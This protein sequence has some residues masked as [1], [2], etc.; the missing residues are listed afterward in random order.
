[1][2]PDVKVSVIIAVYNPGPYLD[3]PIGSLQRQTMPAGEWEAILVDDGST[4]GSGDRLDAIAA[5]NP[6]I[7]AVHIPNSGWPGTPRNV[8]LPMARGEHVL[9]MDH[10]D[11]LGTEAL[12]R[13]YDFAEST[14]ADVVVAKEVGHGFG[15]PLMAFQRTIPDARLGEDPLL[16]LL[17]PHKLFRRSMLEAHGVRFPDGKRRLE[18][19]L[20]VMPAY[21]G[22]KRI[23][24][25][26][27]YPAYHW[28]RRSNDANAS[29]TPVDPVAYYDAVREILD[30]VDAHTE[31]GPLRDEL[32][33]HWYR[34]KTL[35]K[36][37]GPRWTGLS[38]TAGTKRRF[39]EIRRITDERF[40]SRLD[41]DLPVRYRYLARA[42]RAGRMDLVRPHATLTDAIDTSVKVTSLTT[43]E[44]RIDAVLDCTLRASGR[45]LRFDQ[46]DGRAFW[47]PPDELADP[48]LS[49]ADLD[50]TDDLA[51]A[52]VL[53]I[54]RHRASAAEYSRTFPLELRAE[55]GVTISAGT[56]R[57]EID[58]NRFAAGTQLAN[59]VWDGKLQIWIGGWRGTS[60]LPA[61]GLS[62]S[63]GSWWA[64]P[65]ANN[66]GDI[67]ITIDGSSAA[68][69]ETPPEVN[70]PSPNPIGRPSDWLA[71]A[72][73]RR[74]LRRYVPV[75]ARR[76]A[77]N[78]LE[79]VT[80]RPSGW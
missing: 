29:Y 51:D 28:T 63:T 52:S 62:K 73:V 67:S 36:L 1:M 30:I 19:H 16:T 17:T 50:A 34:N 74:A 44:G 57:I 45:H 4:D 79:R 72:R 55:G 76:A 10:D 6:H 9:I 46:R 54:L 33:G 58:M 35:H 60:R 53:V 31:P 61:T 8:A 25:M 21:F 7:R 70:L 75:G 27:D 64:R 48:V 39:E 20:F 47:V 5:E 23:A 38:P 32:Y 43:S 12:E 49:P 13:M 66:R 69:L 59:G 24:V 37:R 65:Y 3:L 68:E 40:D 78:I 42:V 15:V 2:T 80:G 22:A 11:W 77:R 18:D 71:Q 41:R 56:A 26:A 14:G